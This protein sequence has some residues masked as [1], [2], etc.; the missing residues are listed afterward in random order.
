MSSVSPAVSMAASEPVPIAMETS[1]GG[2]RGRIVDAVARHGD[3]AVLRA[4]ISLH[5]RGFGLRR[6]PCGDIFDSG[7]AGDGVGGGLRVARRHD[8]LQ[9]RRPS[10]PEQ[11]RPRYSSTGLSPPRSQKLPLARHEHHG[12]RL[13]R[14]ISSARLSSVRDRCRWRSSNSARPTKTHFPSDVSFQSLTRD[15]FK[16]RT[17]G[18]GRCRSRAALSMAWARGCALVASSAAAMA[19]TSFSETPGPRAPRSASAF[20]R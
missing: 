1:A 19:R 9:C 13:R 12:L 2:E 16:L 17:G 7:F 18:N 10:A 6:L 15:A 8:D 14:A 20:L 5:E 11:S 4:A 3:D